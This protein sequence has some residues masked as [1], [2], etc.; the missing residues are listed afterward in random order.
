MYYC[1]LHKIIIACLNFVWNFHDLGDP[2]DPGDPGYLA[3][4]LLHMP[5]FHCLATLDNYHVTIPLDTSLFLVTSIY[6][7]VDMRLNLYH[8]VQTQPFGGLV[9]YLIAKCS[10]HVFTYVTTLLLLECIMQ[11]TLSFRC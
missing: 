4:W 2:G 6:T 11:T 5:C 8:T 1:L 7:S 3:V 10:R 9:Y